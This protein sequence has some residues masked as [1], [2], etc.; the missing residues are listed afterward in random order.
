[1]LMSS[2]GIFI[3]GA[4]IGW[5]T[6]LLSD[7]AIEQ[8]AA[9]QLISIR[10]IKKSQIET[11][12]TQISDQ[13]RTLAN[14]L[15]IID[16]LKGF[17]A[18]FNQ[19]INETD[20][21][22]LSLQDG[23]KEY[24][25]QQFSTRYQELNAGKNAQSLNYYNANPNIT[26]SLQAAYISENTYALGE[27]NSLVKAADNSTYNQLHEKFHPRI[28]HYLQTFGY[29]DIFL[30][31]LDGN[32]VYSVFKE[33]DFATNLIT[34]PYADTGL[35]NVHKRALQSPNAPVLE[36]FSPYYPSYESAAA[37]IANQVVS[38][39]KVIGVLIFQMPVDKINNIMTYNH[40]WQAAGLGSSGETYLVGPDQL[41]RSQSRFLLEDKNA[42]IELLTSLG[43]ESKDTLDRM[44]SA[45]SSVGLQTIMTQAVEQGLKGNSGFAIIDDYRNVKVLSAWAP[46]N[47]FG[48]RWAIMSEIDEAEAMADIGALA[49]KTIQILLVSFLILMLIALF[50]GTLLGKAI[51]TPIV[52]TIK[53]IETITQS[54][55][56]S[57]RLPSNAQGELAE[58]IYSLNAFFNEV[59][60]LVANVSC[61]SNELFSHSQLIGRDMQFAKDL[62][63]QQAKNA[64][65]VSDS[66]SQMSTA[67][68]EIASAATQVAI[69]VE[70]ADKRCIETSKVASGLGHEMLQLNTCV[71]QVT[72]SITRL[73]IES[74]SI[75]TVLDVIQNIAEQTNLLALNAAIEAARAGESGRGFAV[76]ADEVRTLASRTQQSTEEIRGKIERLQHETQSSV[77]AA[78]NA[79]EMA[80]KGIVTSEGNGQML[81]EIVTMINSLNEM[82][83]HVTHAADRQSAQTL[84]I[85]GSCEQIFSSS[86]EI[87]QAT[88]NTQLLTQELEEHANELLTQLKSFKY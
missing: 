69:A 32:V 74:V 2:A 10:E 81:Q 67:V 60:H 51:A 30:V 37:F 20:K 34:G 6:F 17:S 86:K 11:Y 58:L 76:V 49:K 44:S 70:T 62:T 40:N 26:H 41:M 63:S 54:K 66:I 7:K 75:G 64:E 5:Q 28:N 46:I 39:D 47:I 13:T 14:N 24:Y 18:A 80:T 73:E 82:N 68:Q 57:A 35:G 78:S 84:S 85:A 71:N 87:S 19:H 88:E 29:Y 22:Y 8:R 12:F 27:K 59:Q 50:V 52:N 15:M 21:R 33:L 25:Q 16:A 56:L 61:T 1:M 4:S 43:K 77:L 31:D 48:L 79:K 53:Q 9:S 72:D 83:L 65:S 38:Q 3:S 45:S 42:F 36:D 55:D 23:L